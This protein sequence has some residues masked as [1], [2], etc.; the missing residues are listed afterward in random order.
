MIHVNQFIDS[1]DKKQLWITS[2]AVIKQAIIKYMFENENDLHLKLAT[3]LLNFIREDDKLCK[4]DIHA[5]YAN[6][7]CIILARSH[8]PDFIEDIV[9]TKGCGDLFFYVDSTLLFEFSPNQ[10]RETCVRDTLEYVN[11]IHDDK[12]QWF[13]IY[14]DWV[15]HY[16]NMYGEEMVIKY[17]NRYKDPNYYKEQYIE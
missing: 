13:K 6:L 1:N 15:N 12:S 3:E 2:N 7:L 11:N 17:W 4:R 16:G 8:N 5:N 14:K 9:K 10:T